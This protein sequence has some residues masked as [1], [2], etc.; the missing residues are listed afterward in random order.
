VEKKILL[1]G[2]GFVGSEVARDLKETGDF[3][4]LLISDINLESA[5]KVTSDLSDERIS[6]DPADV[7][8]KKNIVSMMKEF[9]IIADCTDIRHSM[10]VL[11]GAIEAKKHYINLTGAMDIE[12][13]K[14]D[15]GARSAG[16]SAILS[17]GCSPG[18][19]NIMAKHGA[20]QL[21]EVERIQVTFEGS[22]GIVPSPGLLESCLHQFDIE[23]PERVIYKDGEYV[24]VPPFYGEKMV[25]FPGPAGERK[26]YIMAHGETRTLPRYIKGVKHVETRGFWEPETMNAMRIFYDFGFFSKEPIRIKDVSIIPRD[27]L[28]IRLLSWKQKE[29]DRW[30][31]TTFLNVE[32]IGKKDDKKLKYIYDA[33]HPLEWGKIAEAKMTAVPMSIGIQMLAADTIKTRGVFTAEG[34]D[35]HPKT[36]FGELAKRGIKIVERKEQAL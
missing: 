27:F 16:I 30:D 25:K 26:T 7:F 15:N 6:A 36:F 1:L 20:S 9:D 17:L 10:V 13:L 18:I 12:K 32:V 5:E 24:E 14:L 31:W 19:N 23:Q 11:E 34:S 33:T 3:S 29:E 28:K 35:I 22:G 8:D 2:C 21:D 4:K